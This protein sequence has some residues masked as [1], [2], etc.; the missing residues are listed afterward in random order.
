M[1]QEIQEI[2]LQ[3]E[4]AHEASLAYIAN[5]SIGIVE[6]KEYNTTVSQYENKFK[7]VEMMK[8]MTTS[9][10]TVQGL[11]NQQKTILEAWLAYE[12]NFVK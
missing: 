8:S 12:M 9:E 1:L 10:D 5:H 6:K 7:S 11:V 3:I 4:K 2:Q